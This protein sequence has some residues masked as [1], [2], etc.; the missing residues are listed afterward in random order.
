MPGGVGTSDFAKNV[1]RCFRVLA[2]I[3]ANNG[4]TNIGLVNI[5]G[6]NATWYELFEKSFV[7]HLSYYEIKF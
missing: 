2:M 4:R 1:Y 7:I 3:E 6:S 5:V